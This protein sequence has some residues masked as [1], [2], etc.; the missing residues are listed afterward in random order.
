[1]VT[2]KILWNHY[3]SCIE[4]T[5]YDFSTI[6]MWLHGTSNCYRFLTNATMTKQYIPKIIPPQIIKQ[7]K[8]II[9]AVK[10]IY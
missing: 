6:V 10:R 8:Q 9:N 3:S 7:Y 4:L 5:L 2:A 1:M